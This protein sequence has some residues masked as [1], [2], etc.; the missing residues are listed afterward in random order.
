MFY[1]NNIYG[2]MGVYFCEYLLHGD[3]ILYENNIDC[4]VCYMETMYFMKTTYIVRGEDM[5]YGN[6]KKIPRKFSNGFRVRYPVPH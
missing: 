6:T 2:Q 1:E 4:I 3:N 5:L